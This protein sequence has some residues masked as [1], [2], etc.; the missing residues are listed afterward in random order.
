MLFLVLLWLLPQALWATPMEVASG[1]RLS[2]VHFMDWCKTSPST[3]VETISANGCL[4]RPLDDDT[5]SRGFSRQAYWMQLDLTH[6][7]TEPVERWISVG[8]PR[9]A[10]ISLFTRTPAGWTRRDIGT[11]VPRAAQGDVERDQGVLPIRILPKQTI[12]VLLRVYSDTAIDLSTTVWRPADY[13]RVHQRIEFWTVLALGGVLMTILF[14]TFM[15]GLTRQPAYFYF[16]VGLSGA[17]VNTSLATGVFQHDFWPT[18]WPVPSQLIAV[19][20]LLTVLGY[21]LFMRDFLNRVPAH[22]MIDLLLKASVFSSSM[23]LLYG[24]VVDFSPAGRV[25]GGVIS[26]TL[27]LASIRT[28]L[29]WRQGEVHALFLL[30]AFGIYLTFGLLRLALTAGH[31]H[32]I[33]EMAIMGSWGLALSTPVILLGL[34]RRTR[35]LLA[36]LS[37]AETDNLMQLT[38][39][40]QMS[41]ELRSPLDAIL[42]NAQLLARRSPRPEGREEL[43]TIFESGRHLLHLMDHILDYSRG[44]AGAVRITPHPVCLTTFLRGLERSAR[45]LAAK[46]NNIFNLQLQTGTLNSHE[47]YLLLDTDALRQILD[48]LITN[49]ARHTYHGSIQLRLQICPKEQGYSRLDFEVSDTGEGIAPE[50]LEKIFKPFERAFSHKHDGKGAGLG[51]AIA[52][53]LT[54]LM[55]GELSVHSELGQGSRFQFSIL[56]KISEDSSVNE[57]VTVETSGASGYLGPRR[58]ILV[59]DDEPDNRTVL[60]RLLEELGFTVVQA[61]SGNKAIELAQT[62]TNLDLVITDQFMRKGDGW[63]VMDSVSRFLPD[64]PVFL[65]SGGP[66]SPPSSWTGGEFDGYFLRPLDHE[67]LI[68]H[69]GDTLGLSWFYAPMLPLAETAMASLPAKQTSESHVPDPSALQD[70]AVLVETGQIS[71]IKEWAE[72]LGQSNPDL[73]AFGE[74]VMLAVKR[75]DMDTLRALSKGRQ[76]DIRKII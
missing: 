66:P 70:L 19:S 11:H 76:G 29:A 65:V 2:A 17:L 12:H 59:V 51:L 69:I 74:A 18:S 28:Y 63:S 56:A 4:W 35:Q 8:H 23:V 72:A 73:S 20:A 1:G 6:S 25:W 26:L 34:V 31:G 10:E 40:A 53:Q 52:R 62:L 47:L 50:Y 68:Q 45:L 57:S 64:V 55:G 49:A 15:F 71:A 3:S 54:T 33:P 46:Q 13:L 41:H 27:I 9:M 38:F 43:S 44:L 32:W 36:E 30:V 5:I 16:A 67:R 37:R 42:G 75:L 60:S 39:L 14:S 58:T 22:R 7:G 48:N 61:D 24:I 21:Y